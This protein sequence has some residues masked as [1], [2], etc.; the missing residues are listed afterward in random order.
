[1]PPKLVLTHPEPRNARV[2]E[3]LCARGVDVVLLPA[4]RLVPLGRAAIDRDH[5][6]NRLA[7]YRWVVPVSPG[8]VEAALAQ[9]AGDWPRTTGLA[10][11]G[12]GTA[13][14]LARLGLAAPAVRVVCPASAPY[15]ADALL[16]LPAFARGAGARVLVLRGPSGRDAWVDT[17]KARGFEVDVV[18]CYR[19]EAATPSAGARAR[20]QDWAAHD[21][22]VGFAFSSI[23]AIDATL[24]L[25]AEA[26]LRAWATRQ[27][28][29]VLHPRHVAHL[30]KIGWTRTVQIEP[31]EVG[32]VQ[33]LESA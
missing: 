7:E 22:Q 3:R 23:D 29:L 30:A 6:L 19:S 18:Q 10:V 27:T 4:R 12:P 11:V 25:L 15:D 20:L 16:A 9:R 24:L 32:L 28:A 8:A 14:A 31:G 5:P 17:L 1:V 13:A 26:G 33:A 2:A 21:R